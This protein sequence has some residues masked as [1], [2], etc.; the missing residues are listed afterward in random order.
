MEGFV[1]FWG[2]EAGNG[3]SEWLYFAIIFVKNERKYNK[4][5]RLVHINGTLK[6]IGRN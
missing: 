1:K 2:L 5:V 6:K 3:R 4:N